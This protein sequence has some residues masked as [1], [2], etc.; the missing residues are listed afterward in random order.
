M[1][2]CCSKRSQLI[3][4]LPDEPRSSENNLRN[5]EAAISECHQNVPL[6]RRED[7]FLYISNS[8][9]GVVPPSLKAINLLWTWKEYS[10]RDQC[11]FSCILKYKFCSLSNHMTG[12]VSPRKVSRNNTKERPSL[13]V[14]LSMQEWDQPPSKWQWPMECITLFQTLRWLG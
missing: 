5:S 8:A 11:N 9:A 6:S 4:S 1:R 3:L 7:F 10:D 13:K 2:S 14:V 12:S